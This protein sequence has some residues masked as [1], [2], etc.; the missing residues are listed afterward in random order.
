MGASMTD[1]AAVRNPPTA[2]GWKDEGVHFLRAVTDMAE[3]CNVVTGEP[4]FNDKGVKI[5]RSIAQRNGLQVRVDAQFE[6]LRV[7]HIDQT[8]E[9]DL[10]FCSRLARQYDAVCTV[11]KGKLAFIAIDSKITAAGQAVEAATLTRAEGDSHA[12]HTAARNDYSGVRAY[13]NDADR[14]EK[15]SATQGAEIGR[16]HV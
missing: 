4:I 14:A 7:D 6:N 13:W 9:S 5:V 2:Q 3:H 1:V 12:Y 8:H 11:K 16:A 15:R 10:N